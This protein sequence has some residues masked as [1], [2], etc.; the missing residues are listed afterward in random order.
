MYQHSI[1]RRDLLRGGV[2]AV[3][4]VAAAALIGCGDDEEDEAPAGTAAS[5]TETAVDMGD[6][7]R[8]RYVKDDNLQF[9]YNFPEPKKE[10]KPGGVMRVA[11]TWDVGPMD[12][13]VSA[14]GGTIVVPNMV[15]N[16]LIGFVGGP[17]VDPFKQA[18]EPELATSW[19]RSPDGMTYT[20][21]IRPGIKWQNLPPLNGRPF[22]AADAKLAYER[23]ATTGVHQSYWV[24]VASLEAVDDLTLK[25]NMKK[26]TADFINPLA[27][28]YQTIFPHELVDDGSIGKQVIGTGPMILKEAAAGQHAIFDKN[29]DYWERQVLLDGA[30]FRMTPDASARLAA[31]RAGQVEYAYAV[32]DGKDSVDALLSTN[33]DLQINHTNPSFGTIPFGMNLSH[34][35]FQDER[36]RRAIALAI[37]NA[38]ISTIVFSGLAKELPLMPWAFVYDEEPAA[39]SDAFGNW[40]RYD[41]QEAKQLLQAAGAEG[42]TFNNQ[43]FP[44]GAY[45]DR[46]AE[47]LVPMFKE[48]GITMTGGKVDYT[49]FNSQWVGGK[50]AE[51]TTSGWLTIGFDPDAWFY[52]IVYSKSPGNRW[53]LN[54]AQMDQWAAE[55]QVELDPAARREIHRKMWDRSLDQMYWPPLPAQISYEIYQP[56]LRGI[57]FGGPLAGNSSYYDWGDQVAEAWLDK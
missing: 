5:G 43:Y 34:E 39:D 1:P 50:L 14:A 24:N 10:P 31:F 47:L 12:P 29:P 56:W 52:N 18:L 36:V 45:L 17:N 53:K 51:V 57:R 54:D 27:G 13:T 37:D 41:P 19:E 21:K 25:I 48:A 9:P 32:A 49:E 35:K 42:L 2:L 20:F 44:Y 11:A 23:Y 16:R 7:V 38:Q 40:W 28:R 15:Y 4:G 55:Q 6:D 46:I 22:V 26:A 3:G 30:E 33:P 8:G